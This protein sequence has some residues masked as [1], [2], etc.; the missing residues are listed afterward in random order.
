VKTVG[1]M[2]QRRLQRSA[3][4]RLFVMYGVPALLLQVVLPVYPSG[5]GLH[6]SRYADGDFESPSYRVGAYPAPEAPELFLSLVLPAF[7]AASRPGPATAA[8]RPPKGPDLSHG[9]RIVSRAHAPP[10]LAFLCA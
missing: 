9:H 10:L 5:S 8:H 3:L 7:A 1:R 6:C 4:A 2:N